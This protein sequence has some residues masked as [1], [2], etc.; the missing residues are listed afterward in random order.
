MSIFTTIKSLFGGTAA[1]PTTVTAPNPAALAAKN[2][3]QKAKAT[4]AAQAQQDLAVK[5]EQAELD[6]LLASPAGDARDAQL[7]AFAARSTAA[8]LR[9]QAA[10]GVQGMVGWHALQTGAGQRDRRVGKWAKEQ[11]AATRAVQQRDAAWGSVATGYASL[12]Q[13]PSVDV[14]HFM[15]L[16]KTFDAG[17]VQH[18][19]D[20]AAQAQVATWRTTL[21]NRLQAQN[22]AQ[23]SAQHLR[24]RLADIL[25]VAQKGSFTDELNARLATAEADHAA[26]APAN[27]LF[28]TQRLHT[29]INALLPEA[30]A[31]VNN[32]QQSA[33]RLAAA[34][35]LAAEAQ[36]YA[37]QSP[38]KLSSSDIAELK[39]R[40]HSSWGGYATEKSTF[41]AAIAQASKMLANYNAQLA[42]RHEQSIA[43]LAETQAKL[44]A[45]IEAGHGIESVQLAQEINERAGKTLD[46]SRLP[47]EQGAVLD[48]LLSQARE[49]RGLLW[50]GAAH[51]RDELIAKVQQLAAKPLVAKFQE[52]A[53]KEATTAWKA[54]TEKTGGAPAAQFAAFKAACDAAWTP[55]KDHKANMKEVMAK[56]TEQRQALINELNILVNGAD[57]NNID[58]RGVETF[59]REARKQWRECLPSEFAKREAMNAEFDA[60]IKQVDDKLEG[61]RTIEMTRRNNLTM[62]ANAL[63]GK[64]FADQHSTARML[65]GRYNDER[66]S[67]YL[68]RDLDQAAWSSFRHAIDA[69]YSRRE[70]ERKAEVEQNAQAITDL[71]RDKQATVATLA[72]ATALDDLKGLKAALALALL[73]W[74]AP[75][76]LPRGVGEHSGVN[77]DDL[78]KQW[79]STIDSVDTKI[80]TLTK[81][82][83]GARAEQATALAK[84]LDA[85]PAD[86]AA[87]QAAW[88]STSKDS[89]LKKAFATRVNAVLAGTPLLVSANLQTALLDAE[90][91]TQTDSPDAH[92][93][94]RLKRQVQRLS[95]KMSGN[96]QA[97][98]EAGFNA[99]LSALVLPNATQGEAGERLAAVA[100]GLKS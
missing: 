70:A 46:L 67:V 18:Q 7:T 47:S 13:S 58:W 84:L 99:W 53:V 100:A 95:D 44:A 79:Q 64:P 83:Q 77:I 9:W 6:A 48:R 86:T 69:V 33:T 85:S 61:A 30:R 11:I 40:W 39:Q 82:V 23:R 22:D 80:N 55:V 31:A 26:L 29:E 45:A 92:K 74:D 15:E 20:E 21:Q 51:E 59:R 71:I 37:F 3:A 98:S 43:W 93:D 12:L 66:S 28:A 60:V 75:G 88:D 52:Q 62:A 8:A 41:D 35:A 10:Q 57:W 78:V 34:Q 94:A 63:D 24:D 97:S 50:E 89:T 72:A 90:I 19:F 68:P 27:G 91:A 42:D 32:A 81:A 14:R 49:T 2:V 65:M 36:K 4:Q 76:R 96:Q 17:L 5:S 16:D 56:G 73:N 38:E 1:K 54:V 25:T 87:V